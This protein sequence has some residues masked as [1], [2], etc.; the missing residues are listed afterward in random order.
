MEVLV[1]VAEHLVL[2]P[3]QTLPGVDSEAAIR[4]DH[5]I[6]TKADL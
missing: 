5:K 6:T 2:R 1:D 3:E 4:H